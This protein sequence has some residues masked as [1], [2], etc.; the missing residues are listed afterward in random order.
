MNDFTAAHADAFAVYFDADTRAALAE[1]LEEAAFGAV[2]REEDYAG[3]D[4]PRRADS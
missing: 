1:D 3:I 2:I 4:G